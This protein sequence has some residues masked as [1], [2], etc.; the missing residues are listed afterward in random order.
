MEMGLVIF[1]KSFMPNKKNTHE[2]IRVCFFYEEAGFVESS[3]FQV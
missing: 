2:R 3:T 1:A